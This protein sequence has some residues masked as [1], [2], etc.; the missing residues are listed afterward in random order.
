MVLTIVI[1]TKVRIMGFSEIDFYLFV[2]CCRMECIS[3]TEFGQN[4]EL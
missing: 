2:L 4:S 1:L 3:E